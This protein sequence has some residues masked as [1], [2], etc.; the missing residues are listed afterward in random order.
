[1][2]VNSGKKQSSVVVSDIPSVKSVNVSMSS[3][4]LSDRDENRYNFVD[5]TQSVFKPK[6]LNRKRNLTSI[7]SDDNNF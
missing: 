3:I 1:M 6:K 2:N 7:V 4:N 5:N